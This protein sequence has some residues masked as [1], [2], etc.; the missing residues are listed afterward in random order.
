LHTFAVRLTQGRK[1]RAATNNNIADEG[2]GIEET[3][4]TPVAVTT[5]RLPTA[6]KLFKRAD[7][8]T[9]F[10]KEFASPA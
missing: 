7:N 6:V 2:S 4:A 10:E 5:P 3:R 9:S 8:P 1:T